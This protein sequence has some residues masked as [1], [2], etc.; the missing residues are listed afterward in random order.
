MNVTMQ[1]PRAHP[2]SKLWLRATLKD[3]AK[4]AGVAP[5]TVSA[6]LAN[7][8]HCYASDKTRE[9]VLDAARRLSYQPNALSRA[10][11]G[12]Q[13][14]TLGLVLRDLMGPTL[15]I[16]NIAA[17]EDLAQEAGY[18]LLI[19]AHQNNPIRE[20][21]LIRSFLSQRVDGF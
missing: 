15:K 8:P 7:K 6:I 5:S 9:R 2:A 3:V 14:Y 20:A 12:Q 16:E 1:L 10:L 4:Q 21:N 11:L 18:R 17:I 19:A 13:T